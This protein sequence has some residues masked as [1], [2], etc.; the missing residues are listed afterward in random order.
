MTSNDVRYLGVAITT[1]TADGMAVTETW[2]CTPA[3]AESLRA[4]FGEPEARTMAPVAAVA[5]LVAD[6]RHIMRVILMA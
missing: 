5:E 4:L 1:I 2:P 6:P 3:I